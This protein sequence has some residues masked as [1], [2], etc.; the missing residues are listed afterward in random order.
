MV[1]KL[2]F[3][4]ATDRSHRTREQAWA[5]PKTRPQSQRMETK[6]THMAIARERSFL[7]QKVHEKEGV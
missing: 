1:S 5:A 7:W 4:K 2:C 6:N 3:G